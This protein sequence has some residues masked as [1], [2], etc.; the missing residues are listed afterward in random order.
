MMSL[1]STASIISS[2]LAAVFGIRAATVKVR[3][4]LDG[5]ISERIPPES[6][7]SRG[8]QAGPGQ[9]AFKPGGFWATFFWRDDLFFWLFSKISPSGGP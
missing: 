6:L 5:F 7:I 3:D 9:E 2:L 1:L 8:L 4:N